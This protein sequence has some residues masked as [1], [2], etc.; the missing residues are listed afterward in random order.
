MKD[1]KQK[2]KKEK[3]TSMDVSVFQQEKIEKYPKKRR[4]QPF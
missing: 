2:G 3:F 1:E 4:R